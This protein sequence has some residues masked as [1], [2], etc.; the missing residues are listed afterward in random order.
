MKVIECDFCGNYI[1]CTEVQTYECDK[2]GIACEDCIETIVDTLFENSKHID[3]YA[4]LHITVSDEEFH[5]AL[6]EDMIDND[7][8]R[9][10]AVE[11]YLDILDKNRE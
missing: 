11:D 1:D 5:D 4:S 8:F 7:N 9:Y 6:M 2:H 3:Y 10:Q